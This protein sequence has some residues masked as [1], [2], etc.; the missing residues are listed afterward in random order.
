MQFQ[1]S[2]LA[3][4]RWKKRSSRRSNLIFTL[5]TQAAAPDLNLISLCVSKKHT[6]ESSNVDDE[7]QSI[8]KHDFENLIPASSSPL[9]CGRRWPTENILNQTTMKR[10]STSWDMWAGKRNKVLESSI[11]L[12]TFNYWSETTCLG[13][14]SSLIRFDLMLRVL[15]KGVTSDARCELGDEIWNSNSTADV[16]PSAHKR[17]RVYLWKSVWTVTTTKLWVKEIFRHFYRIYE[18]N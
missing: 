3:I 5:F 11:A 7:L 8:S 4:S 16:L 6:L 2:F 15:V 18:F 9:C 10:N 14:F 1:P 12:A 17:W 13:F